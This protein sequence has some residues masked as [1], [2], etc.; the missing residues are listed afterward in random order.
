MAIVGLVAACSPALDWR[1]TLVPDSGA[2][3]VFPCKPDAH[4]RQV[5]LAGAGRKMHLASCMA[6]DTVYAVSHVDVGDLGQVTE[7]MQALRALAAENVGGAAKV[8]APQTVP[9]MTPHPLAERLAVAGKRSDGSVIEAQ[10]IFFT[11]ATVVY[12]A[13]VVGG[14]LDPDAVDTFF[15]ALKLR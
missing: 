2:S 10:A 7:A 3:A 14:H 15:S 1:D 12:Q 11:Q 9:G 13:T 4:V 8:I 5:V 6:A